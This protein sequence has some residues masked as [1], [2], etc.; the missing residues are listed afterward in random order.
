MKSCIL[1]TKTNWIMHAVC[2]RHGVL[3]CVVLC[4][5]MY[6]S[7]LQP[8]LCK[9]RN[10]HTK[11]ERVKH[12]KTIGLVLSL[13]PSS[14]HHSLSPSI[15]SQLITLSTDD[16]RYSSLIPLYYATMWNRRPAYAYRNNISSV[17]DPWVSCS[18]ALSSTYHSQFHSLFSPVLIRVW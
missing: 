10:T 13:S 12:I 14:L 1:P 17:H 11:P 6:W 8:C 2:L 9:H 5:V 4:T 15:P 3:E 7:Y 16:R 18:L